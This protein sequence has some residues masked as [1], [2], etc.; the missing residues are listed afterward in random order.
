MGRALIYQI[1]VHEIRKSTYQITHRNPFIEVS[2]T[3]SLRI[4]AKP[5]LRIYSSVYR[6]ALTTNSVT[7]EFLCLYRIVESIPSRRKR[8]EREAKRD[9]KIYSTPIETYPSTKE[10]AL[11]M[12]AWIYPATPRGR[13][14]D[15][16]V[17]SVLAPSARGKTFSRIIDEL[18]PIRDNIA[19]TLLQRGDEL[20]S[21]DDPRA[22]QK[23]EQWLPVV[24]CMA[25]V[26]LK[27]DF[28]AE[29]S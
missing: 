11:E 4:S 26:M 15:M 29:L 24:K 20:V 10:Q 27:N 25:R 1:D 21:F 22:I 9:G 16:S 2:V 8:L 19:H 17:D 3:G 6:E 28:Q 7:Y 18:A 23:I 13:W 12:L 5:D 14:D